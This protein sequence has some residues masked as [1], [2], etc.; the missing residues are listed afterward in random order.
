MANKPNTNQTKTAQ[1]NLKYDININK[2]YQDFIQNIDSI[3]SYVNIGDQNNSKLLDNISKDIFT[4]A[5]T[6][7]QFNPENSPQESRCHAFYRIIGFPV[8]AADDRI[9]NPGHD[10]IVEEGRK[11]TDDEKL[12]IVNNPLLGFVGLS[13]E[14]ER[15]FKYYLKFFSNKSNGLGGVYA[16]SLLNIRNF[17][18]PFEKNA[19]AIE[20]PFTIYNQS[21]KVKDDGLVGDNRIKLQEYVDAQNKVPEQYNNERF[22]IIKPFAVDPRIDFTT[23]SDRRIAVPFVRD[24]SQLRVND[25]KS[26]K[27]PLLEKIIRD[28]FSLENQESKSGTLVQS[29]I[30]QMK[31][32]I[33]IKD[34][35][36]IQTISSG[37]I[38]GITE[39]NKISKITEIIR[40]TMLALYK[41]KLGAQIA[42]VKHYW[43]PIPDAKGPE[44]GCS[45]HPIF[46]HCYNNEYNGK[47]VTAPDFAILKSQY[48]ETMSSITQEVAKLNAIPDPGGYGL[49]AFI[50]TFDDQT[51]DALGNTNKKDLDK[52]LKEREQYLSAANN[53]LRTIEIITGEFSGL[54]LIDIMVI[55]GGLYLIPPNSL[56]G[57]LDLDA[58][59][60]ARSY[61]KS[62]P[63][64]NPS[65]IQVALK[66]LTAK[67]IFLYSIVEKFSQK[68]AGTSQDQ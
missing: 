41:A 35:S 52:R 42:Q 37:N 29:A 9:Y 18:S 46:P 16:L 43:L 33:N 17:S 55:L 45:I 1:D 24:D 66:D 2:V 64:N 4:G 57:F 11:I 15:L 67:V 38:Y 6:S 49:S 28:R 61:I 63:E 5:A 60:R 12:S 47:F 7:G 32:I 22:H 50:N 14:R 65:N 39:V 23:P 27:K 48:I 54:G 13:N 56:L 21:Y 40:A 31:N 62:L 51:S 30:E 36:L 26:V 19:D 44:M 20:K 34:D 58:Y 3:R 8:I 68:F 59:S 10:I 25:T 53:H